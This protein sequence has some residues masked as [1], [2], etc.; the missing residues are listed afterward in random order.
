M[1]NPGSKGFRAA[2]LNQKRFV[3]HDSRIRQETGFPPRG[4]LPALHRLAASLATPNCQA[5]WQGMNLWFGTS[6]RLRRGLTDSQQ[7][8]NHRVDRGLEA[9][10]HDMRNERKRVAR[11]SVQPSFL[12]GVNCA[13]HLNNN[14]IGL[15]QLNPSCVFHILDRMPPSSKR[16]LREWLS[17]L[18]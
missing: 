13:M 14:E 4:V 15:A 7:N 3:T 10:E 2:Q 17:L 12:Y 5:V 9:E 16:I 1:S 6:T 8:G 18:S 11:G